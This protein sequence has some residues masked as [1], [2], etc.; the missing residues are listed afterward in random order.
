MSTD[1]RNDENAT[2][3]LYV[4]RIAASVVTIQV[5]DPETRDIK[6]R[7]VTIAGEILVEAQPDDAGRLVIHAFRR[8]S[9][10]TREPIEE[11]E[12][13]LAIAGPI[14]D[15]KHEPSPDSRA[16]Q[17]DAYI[18][19]P[20]LNRLRPYCEDFDASFPQLEVLRGAITWRAVSDKGEVVLTLSLNEL[21][22]AAEDGDR[23]TGFLLDG[24]KGPLIFR[25]LGT[26]PKEE[27]SFMPTALS[28][29]GGGPPAAGAGTYARFRVNV[30][31]ICY[32]TASTPAEQDEVTQI[33]DK[34][35]AGACE[36]WWQKGGIK[37]V[38]DPNITFRDVPALR[39]IGPTENTNLVADANA[40][41]LTDPSVVEVY[42]VDELQARLGTMTISIGG[43]A[44][45][46]R[47]QFSY[48]IISVLE[49]RHNRYLLAHELG[50]VLGVT[51]PD[52]SS[53]CPGIPAGEGCTVMVPDSPNSSRNTEI[54]LNAVLGTPLPTGSVFTI[55][56][57]P[58]GPWAV[59][60]PQGFFH[61]VRDFPSDDGATPSLVTTAFPN[62]YSYSDV[63]NAP[64]TLAVAGD[65][66]YDVS[67]GP[68]L[69]AGTAALSLF[70][71]NF[72]PRHFTPTWGGTNNMYVR[73][74][75]CQVSAP[76]NVHLF[77]A[78]PGVSSRPLVRLTEQGGLLFQGIDQP[79]PGRYPRG[80]KVL[81]QDWTVPVGYPPHC[82]VFAVAVSPGDP[83][84]P[85]LPTESLA[86][87]GRMIEIPNTS[88]MTFAPGLATSNDIAQRNLNITAVP[89]EVL[90]IALPWM[91]IANPFEEVARVA[92]TVDVSDPKFVK[93]L[94]LEADDKVLASWRPDGAATI[95]V[96]EQLPRGVDIPVRLSVHLAASL[97]DSG[98]P[99]DVG[100]LVADKHVA[101]YCH[102]LVPGT[103]DE[104][105]A[106]ALDTLGGGLRDVGVAFGIPAAEE[107]AR[108][109]GQM[110]LRRYKR[111]GNQLAALRKLA[112]RLAPIAEALAADGRPEALVVQRRLDE[113]SDA[114]L[115]GERNRGG[116]TLAAR[117]LELA[118]RI[119]ER[120]ANAYW[121]ARR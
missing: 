30:R 79:T 5:R 45:G 87:A 106:R 16:E 3:P 14:N 65:L 120:A 63:W 117:A 121:E 20:L 59:D 25:R 2:L 74:H 81:R 46:C 103:D 77:L 90:M 12:G 31:F 43:T 107:L 21:A 55:L 52:G 97:P 94:V 82:C 111:K 71:D 47:T 24:E 80:A 68:V 89:T 98:L 10:W 17:F 118:D 72:T 11:L 60:S 115:V 28:A 9:L 73:V 27:R 96:A 119:Q 49:A 29:C 44:F 86:L 40:A 57:D 32:A 67:S 19:Y 95:T 54:N 114:L 113:L 18:S 38:P 64:Y 50:H 112:A 15:L 116:A 83:H 42:I 88:F 76:V 1:N 35:V 61:I 100:F 58:A 37:V 53:A 91:M 99:I 34:L 109:V 62:H 51:H 93:R 26:E 70:N 66:E 101:G 69:P 108:S 75:T 8:V 56:A 22:S 13:P 92:L 41:G 85:A 104:L 7:D 105:I 102:L 48:I 36:V 39:V 6:P 4:A 33:A 84:S 110:A 78:V 23:V